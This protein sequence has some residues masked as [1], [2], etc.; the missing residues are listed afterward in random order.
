MNKEIEKKYNEIRSEMLMLVEERTRRIE[1]KIDR[2]LKEYQKQM[3]MISELLSGKRKKKK[4]S[5]KGEKPE[6][7]EQTK[8][9]DS[10]YY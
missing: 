10:E 7:R 6:E 1:E 2:Q 4:V 9:E 8:S 3:K 5:R